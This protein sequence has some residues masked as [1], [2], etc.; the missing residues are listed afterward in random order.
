MVRAPAFELDYFLMDPGSNLRQV[1]FFIYANP[2]K[3]TLLV[4]G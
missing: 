3:L 4:T 1:T 2:S